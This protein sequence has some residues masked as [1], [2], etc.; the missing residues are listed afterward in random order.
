VVLQLNTPTG[1]W[2]GTSTVSLIDLTVLP[3][4]TLTDDVIGTPTECCIGMVDQQ[5]S[6]RMVSGLGT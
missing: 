6:F 1:L 3:L 2:I 4:N 5:L